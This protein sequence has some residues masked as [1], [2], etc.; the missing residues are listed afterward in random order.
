MGN[1]QDWHI[2]HKYGQK[3]ARLEMECEPDWHIWHK[4]EHKEARLDM[5]NEPDWHIW[6]KYGHTLAKH[7][8]W[9]YYELAIQRWDGGLI[10]IRIWLFVRH[11]FLHL[12]EWQAYGQRG[13]WFFDTRYCIACGFHIIL[14]P[15]RLITLG[16]E[17]MTEGNLM[18][19]AHDAGRLFHQ[20]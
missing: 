10:P 7:L 8:H 3:V 4:Y 2:W 12:R 18:V 9:K 6:H 13:W 1:E 19:N 16:R 11:I 20:I 17:F 15:S 5:E 14:K